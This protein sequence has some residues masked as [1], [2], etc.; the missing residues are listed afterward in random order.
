MLTQLFGNYL[1]KQQLVSPSHLI[2][3][4]RSASSTRVKLGVLA[5][6]AGLMTPEQVEEV[7]ELQKTMDKRIGDIMVEKKYLTTEQVTSLL[8]SQKSGHLVLGQALID[9]GHMTTSQ[10]AN[11]LKSF[12]LE[13]NITDED[14]MDLRDAVSDKMLT[15][16]YKLTDNANS[17]HIVDYISLLFKNLIRFIGDD[18]IPRKIEKIPGSSS[19]GA[20][21]RIKNGLSAITILDSDDQTVLEFASR[22]ANESLSMNDNYTKAC[23]SEFLN[24]H[25]GLF[26]VNLS[27]KD[28]IELELEPQQYYDNL[29]LSDLG[30]L[31]V[32]PVDFTFGTINFI[33]CI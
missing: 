18:F 32:F 19:Q 20:T 11:A 10:F 2:E 24:L 9:S 16:F 33:V 25:N 12:K 28:G 4:L 21:Q 8:K 14:F 22:F 7:H 15:N 26:A 27:N 6:N 17:Q 5:I 30:T 23:V 29:N 13:N 1:L 31:Y 3:A